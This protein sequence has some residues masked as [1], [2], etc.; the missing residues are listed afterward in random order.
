MKESESVVFDNPMVDVTNFTCVECKQ[1]IPD[2]VNFLES[3]LNEF[4]AP[5]C[6]VC[7]MTDKYVSQ[8]SFCITNQ[9]I[10]FGNNYDNSGNNF[11]WNL[12]MD[13]FK[14]GN[15]PVECPIDIFKINCCTESL[16]LPL[17]SSNK[18]IVLEVID[19][20]YTDKEITEKS[21]NRGVNFQDIRKLE[22]NFGQDPKGKKIIFQEFL[23]FIHS[24]PNLS[25]ELRVDKLNAQDEIIG[26]FIARNVKN[27]SELQGFHQDMYIQPVKGKSPGK[28]ISYY[29]Y[30]SIDRFYIENGKTLY[31]P[32]IPANVMMVK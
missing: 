17:S 15:E 8:I 5:I 10:K 24:K 6:S 29:G 30:E 12:S 16:F 1:E 14:S 19:V 27:I 28:F 13:N 31:E 21:E 4:K 18:P 3:D 2:K 9:S 22:F 20:L 7:I 26:G 32:Y 11:R 23:K 25:F